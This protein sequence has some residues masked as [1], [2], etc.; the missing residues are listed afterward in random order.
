LTHTFCKNQRTGK[1]SLYA[2][3]PIIILLCA[4]FRPNPSRNVGGAAITKV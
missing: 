1:S 3:L 4:K 2:Q